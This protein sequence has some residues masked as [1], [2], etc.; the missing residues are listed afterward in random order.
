[1]KSLST[2]LI[3][4]FKKF[5]QRFGPTPEELEEL[6]EIDEIVNQVFN[7]NN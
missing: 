3:S 1:M 7:L 6:Q 5:F 4:P 2:I